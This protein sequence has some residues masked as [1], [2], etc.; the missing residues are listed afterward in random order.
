MHTLYDYMF[1]RKSVRKFDQQKL[2]SS[3]LTEIEAMIAGIEPLSK[4]NQIKIIIDSSEE[5]GGLFGVK[6]PHYFLVYSEEKEHYLTNAGYVLQH[7]DLLLSEMKIGCCWLG[8]AKP[9]KKSELAGDL[10]FVIAMAFGT[11]N[12]AYYRDSTAYNRKAMSEISMGNGYSALLEAVRVAPSATN[13]QPWYM[14]VSEGVIDIY[15]VKNNM[16][17]AF[18]LDRMN[19]IDIGIAL[20]HLQIAAKAHHLK[21]AIQ[22]N[23]KN[24]L[25]VVKGYEA[26]YRINICEEGV[27]ADV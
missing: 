4:D 6:A 25:P 1:K 27:T 18:V 7:V 14:S 20:C 12:E 13:S 21:L 9:S 17:K 22:L 5:V 10:N 15:R 26:M 11:P 23:S 3:I 19:Q 24:E 16:L 2:D 8:M